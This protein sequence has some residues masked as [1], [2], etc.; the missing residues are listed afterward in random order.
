MDALA[1][2]STI[3]A[4]VGT[5]I[6]VLSYR[7]AAR[8]D[9]QALHDDTVRRICA[10]VVKEAL[11]PV[12]AKL[13]AITSQQVELKTKVDLFWEGIAKQLSHLLHSPHPERAELDGLLEKLAPDLPGR[14]VPAERL[15]LKDILSQ[16]A[17]SKDATQVAVTDN[18]GGVQT[19][20]IKPGEQ[21]GA[22]LLLAALDAEDRPRRHR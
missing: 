8:K 19:M 4:V 12:N 13:D 16:I 18:E 7:T 11:D 6:A 2:G 9:T 1:I 20:P 22:G 15:R 14:L 21:F 17:A 5:A 10:A 3:M